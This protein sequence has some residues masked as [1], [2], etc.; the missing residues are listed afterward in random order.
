VEIMA[1]RKSIENAAKASWI[2]VLVPIGVRLVPGNQARVDGDAVPLAIVTLVLCAVCYTVGLGAGVYA[3][4]H[5][6]S[7][8]KE[9][10]LIPA[11]IG[12]VLSA[13]F[14]VMWVIFV[15]GV[16]RS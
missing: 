9:R 8:G 1:D 15:T 12:V 3:L 14:L 11:L 16:F 2:A 10:V 6:R 4:A 13:F 7:V 5:V